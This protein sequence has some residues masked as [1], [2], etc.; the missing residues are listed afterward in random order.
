VT[1]WDAISNNPSLPWYTPSGFGNYFPA[2]AK[3]NFRKPALWQGGALWGSGVDTQAIMDNELA[4]AKGKI[5]AWMFI[6]YP[7]AEL[8]DPGDE[9][10]NS[11]IMIPFDAYFASPIRQAS[12]I[13]FCFLLSWFWF[14][15]LGGKYR[16]PFANWFATKM[17]DPMYQRVNYFSVDRPVISLYNDGWAAQAAAWTTFKSITGGVFDMSVNSVTQFG[18][19]VQKAIMIYGPNSN[20]PS[21]PGQDPWTAQASRDVAT[22]GVVPG[23]VPVASITP[24]QDRRPIGP[25]RYVDHATRPQLVAH[26]AAAIALPNNHCIPV[27]SGSEITEGGNPYDAGLYDAAGWARGAPKP[28]SHT[29]ETDGHS[30]AT[31]GT[32]VVILSGAGWTYIFPDPS[33]VQGAYHNDEME[34]STLNDAVTLTSHDRLRACDIV[35]SKA[36]GRGTG[37][38]KVDGVP[39]GTIDF[40]GPAS[41][42][43]TLFTVT[44]ANDPPI[45]HSV[46]VVCDGTGAIR[47]DSFRPTWKP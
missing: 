40:N 11:D 9:V 31:S 24:V 39:V 45:A 30:A 42:H 15:Y 17:Q 29:Y 41:V 10:A 21:T 6:W 32:N 22:W 8:L 16:T 25:T 5:D 47:V 37:T 23:A 19:L 36:P 1:R 12:G 13:K 46:S 14:D 35:G 28:Q 4:N 38:V 2:T 43:E 18:N 33:G 7:P 20:L 44:F 34:T 3:Y 26:Y 27:Y